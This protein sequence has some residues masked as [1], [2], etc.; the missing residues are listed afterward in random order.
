MEFTCID[1]QKLK[2]EQIIKDLY[3]AK[4]NNWISSDF[5]EE[6]KIKHLDIYKPTDWVLR[7]GFFVL[8]TF[9]IISSIAMVAGIYIPVFNENI[10]PL[11]F[12]TC[13]A[14]FVFL[15][16]GYNV[17][18]NYNTGVDDALLYW[19]ILLFLLTLFYNNF[20]G[21]I[22]YESNFGILFYVFVTGIVCA[23]C[24]YLFLDRFLMLVS[25]GSFLW[26]YFGLIEEINSNL[27]F[28]IDT[29]LLS[30]LLIFLFVFL[31]KKRTKNEYSAYYKMNLFMDSMLIISVYVLFNALFIYSLKTEYYLFSDAEVFRDSLYLKFFKITTFLIPILYIYAGIKRKSLL[32]INCGVFC[33]IISIL[34]FVADFSQKFSPI[35]VLIGTGSFIVL[36]SFLFDKYQK[37]HLPQLSYKD[38]KIPFWFNALYKSMTIQAQGASHT[39]ENKESVSMG[40]GSFGGGGSSADF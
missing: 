39:P 40:G 8:T 3:I 19:G 12:L 6:W 2:N 27:L 4:E 18:I 7:I 21:I 13:I 26:L 5:F 35:Y 33:L 20:F 28:Y 17:K 22:S 30:I 23:L 14:I 1:L 15:I 37:K 24:S 11:S 38:S 32:W 10:K 16:K 36:V 29:L 25:F 31:Q 9:A 34:I